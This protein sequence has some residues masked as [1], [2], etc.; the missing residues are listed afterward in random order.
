MTVSKTTAAAKKKAAAARAEKSGKVRRL[1][2]RGLDLTLPKVLSSDVAFDYVDLAEG[3]VDIL[4]GSIRLLKSILGEEQW[5]IVRA[6]IRADGVP[7][8]DLDGVLGK[9]ASD[10]FAA[11]GVTQGK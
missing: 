4:T 11:F 7:M 8:E 6:K 9:L 10:A 1:K 3:D 5:I 2:F